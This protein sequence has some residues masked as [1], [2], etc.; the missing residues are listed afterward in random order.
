VTVVDERTL[1]IRL[2]AP[3]STFLMKIAAAP[4]SVIDRQEA[5]ESSDWW[6]APNGSGPF[7]IAEWRRDELM[8]LAPFDEFF[9]GRAALDRVEIRLG[10]NALQSFNLYQAGEI[11]IDSLS[12]F[13]IDRALA[14]ESGLSDQ[15][16]ITPLFAV[17]YVALRTDLAPLDDPAIRRAL[18]LAFPREK[19][20]LVSYDGHVAPARGL[21]PD[22]M[23]GR[24][25]P[26]EWP[27]YDPEAALAAIAES[28]YGSVENVPPIQIYITGGYTGAEAM[29]DYI[30]HSIGLRIEVIQVEWEEFI[31]NLGRRV[32]PAHELYWGA[33][34]PDPESLLESLFG[35]R[36]A[37]NYVGYHNPAFDELLDG[38]A[39]EQ[40]PDARAT[41]YLQAQQLL[42][43][44]G[45]IIPFYFDVAYTLQRPYVKGLELTPL[46]ILRLDSVWM[47]R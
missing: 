46:G 30:M 39:Q 31:G 29:R 19:I 5:E 1:E 26:V 20:A 33:D 12:V 17:N 28:R 10:A 7:E 43:D 16:T 2:S 13:G 41:L 34:Y 11:D 42:V 6:R 15:V 44:D 24:D 22:G 45:V 25:W 18:Q 27:A 23:L 32:Y 36:S 47:E 38:A 35:S 9:A 37:D 3:R 4:A 14:P 8:V 21:I 40:D